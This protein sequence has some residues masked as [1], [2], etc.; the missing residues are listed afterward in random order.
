MID[1]KI[2]ENGYCKDLEQKELQKN[3]PPKKSAPVKCAP[4]KMA[5]EKVKARQNA[6]K[7]PGKINDIKNFS[8][9]SWF[10]KQR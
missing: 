4:E 2:E 1:L 7:L 9:R 10:K 3:K 5:Q 6:L 8:W